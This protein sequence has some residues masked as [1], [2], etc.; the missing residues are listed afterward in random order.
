MVISAIYSSLVGDPHILERF[1]DARHQLRLFELKI[2]ENRDPKQF[3]SDVTKI[4]VNHLAI[5]VI[6]ENTIQYGVD[7]CEDKSH[8]P[9]QIVKIKTLTGRVHLIPIDQFTTVG[10]LFTAI[11]EDPKSSQILYKRKY[12]QLTDK[13]QDLGINPKDNIMYFTLKIKGFN[14]DLDSERKV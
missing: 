3:I 4:P 10:D 12:T 8:C 9:D 2:P 11:N 6:N 5:K 7:C 14:D 1:P 13:L